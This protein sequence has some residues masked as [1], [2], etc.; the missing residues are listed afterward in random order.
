[1]PTSQD[2]EQPGN[3]RRNGDVRQPVPEKP[4]IREMEEKPPTCDPGPK[5]PPEAV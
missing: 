3:E 5:Q 1:M 2:E 4:P